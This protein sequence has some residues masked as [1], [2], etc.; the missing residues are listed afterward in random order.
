MVQYGL[1][2]ILVVL[3]PF[4]VV[5]RYLQGVFHLLSHAGFTVFG[6]RIPIVPLAAG[7]ILAGLIV[8][9]VRNLT[10]RKIAGLLVILGFI[11]ISQQTMDAYL[12]MSFFDLQQ[13]WHYFAYGAYTFFFF[14]AFHARRMPMNRM[15]LWAFTSAIMMSL[16]DETFQFFMSQ[17]VFDI[18][19]IAK[20]GLGVFCGLIIV[21]FVTE[22]YGTVD[23]T[24]QSV[25]QRK[26]RDYFRAPRS[27]LVMTGA[28]TLSAILIS[29]LLTDHEN[30]DLSLLGIFGL[31]I[32]IMLIVHLAQFRLARKSLVI[33]GVVIVL[34]L[35]VSVALNFRKN[36]VHNAYG[37][38]VYRG[39]PL[40]FFDIAIYPNG[41][42]RL[43]DKKHHFRPRDKE[44]FLEQAPDI[45]LIGSGS[46]GI[47]GKGFEQGTGT[48]FI[49][50]RFTLRGTQVI[51]L[52]TPEACR[53][54]NQLKG[55]GKK[56]LFIIHNTC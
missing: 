50:N 28:L 52:P 54:Y 20:D 8:W 36:I 26:L 6:F 18:S 14:R 39:I 19:D 45:L 13:N 55:D 5:T 10:R 32:L 53:K 49:F 23:F 48:H 3:T 44:Y 56:V 38:T 51:I 31:F 4:I 12:G 41:L 25:P 15:I 27:A 33:L 43:V 30:W 16:F 42:F 24:L 17:R 35:S 2:T 34:S 22:T 7:I 9:Q 46:R 21:L 37:I 47:G 11:F 29:P 40:P 1:F